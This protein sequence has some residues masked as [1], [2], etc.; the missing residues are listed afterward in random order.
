V[1]DLYH[2]VHLNMHV[3]DLSCFQKKIVKHIYKIF[4]YRY[5]KSSLLSMKSDVYSFGVVLLEI[6][7][8]Q[9]VIDLSRENCNIVE[10][11]R[12]ILESGDI[13]SIVDPN[14]H[15]D[16]DTSSA[17]KVVEL[18]MSCVNPTSNERPNMSQVVHVLNECLETCEK[19]R[20]SKELDLRSPLELSIVVDTEINPK[21]R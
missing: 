15:Q 21:A 8:G 5:H 3:F 10:W 13:E 4:S 2:I 18:A 16:Y 20:K 12:S 9:P 1:E 17:W 6:I 19:W 7:S 11:T 14:L